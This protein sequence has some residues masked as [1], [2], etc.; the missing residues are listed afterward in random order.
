MA[1]LPF[2]FRHLSIAGGVRAAAGR[3]PGKIAYKHGDRTRS[4][5]QLIDRIDR[6]TAALRGDCGLGPG[7]HG[8]IVAATVPVKVPFRN[9]RRVKL[10]MM[11]LHFY[12]DAH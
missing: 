8:A 4:Y 2:S 3:D 10:F 11:V 1:K 12:P 9:L 5:G 7:D 6:V